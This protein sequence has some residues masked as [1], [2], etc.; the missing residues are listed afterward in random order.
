MSSAG[1]SR[2]VPYAYQEDYFSIDDILATQERVPSR[3]EV[4]L[5]NLGKRNTRLPTHYILNFYSLG[6]F[7]NPHF[8]RPYMFE[9]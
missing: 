5:H 3:F 8:G 9:Y 6:L 7:M 1:P 4:P 2:G